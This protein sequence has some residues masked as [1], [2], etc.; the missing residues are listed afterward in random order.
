M[1]TVAYP[2]RYNL[3]IFLLFFTNF[4]LSSNNCPIVKYSTI[5]PKKKFCTTLR[6]R[7]SS[8]LHMY[9][10]LF[11]QFFRTSTN[12]PQTNMTFFGI[13]ALFW[14]LRNVRYIS[15]LDPLLFSVAYYVQNLLSQFYF[16]GK[17]CLPTPTTPWLGSVWKEYCR[18]QKFLSQVTPAWPTWPVPVPSDTSGKLY[19]CARL[20]YV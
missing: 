2:Q 13:R 10:L 6:T 11:P 16:E 8:I 17:Q 18:T 20:S 3:K 12:Y 4:K 15:L 5:E 1:S 14:E 9:N 7:N 19:D